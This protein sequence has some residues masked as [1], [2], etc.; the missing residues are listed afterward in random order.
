M[1]YAEIVR[2]RR[3]L[4]IFCGIAAALAVLS[5]MTLHPPGLQP[6]LLAAVPPG[7]NTWPFSIVV[8]NAAFVS[9]ILATILG[10]S[11]NRYRETGETIFTFPVTRVAFAARVLL[12]DAAAVL[13]ALAA[14]LAL[15]M[16]PL[17]SSGAL[18]RA[19]IDPLVG[20]RLAQCAGAAVL[21][22]GLVQA[23][24]AWIPF[25]A[26][27][28]AGLSWPLFMVLAVLANTPI[29][30]PGWLQTAFHLTNF[31]NPLVYFQSRS[32]PGGLH[33]GA[34]FGIS[35]VHQALAAW[36]LAAAAFALAIEG[37]RRQQL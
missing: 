25:R 35:I 2:V 5:A 15:V 10:T 19:A 1:S 28:V 32:D 30:L 27:F 8:G 18:Q 31:V 11:L 17:A 22:L 24:S 9:A 21:W 3:T 37:W 20:P 6:G 34:L 4:V 7:G 23:V 33:P 36:T 29:G 14:V 12:V 13:L 26:G 16:L